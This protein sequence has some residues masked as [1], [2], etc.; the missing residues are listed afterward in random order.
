MKLL[1]ENGSFASLQTLLSQQ[2]PIAGVLVQTL[3]LF[4]LK[5]TSSFGVTDKLD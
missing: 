5:Q 2:R 3:S 1:M 4:I